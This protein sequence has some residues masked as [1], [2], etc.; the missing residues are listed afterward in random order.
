MSQPTRPSQSSSSGDLEGRTVLVF[1]A[2]GQ[3]AAGVVA[4][5]ADRGAHVQASA[6]DAARLD[7][8][9]ERIGASGGKM[10][11]EV[12][13]ATDDAAVGAYVDRVAASGRIDGVF[14]GIGATPAAL[15]YPARATELDLETFLRRPGSSPA[16]RS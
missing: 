14:N 11:T 4:E 10:T 8:L 1:A 13:D 16:R 12:V 9:A 3:I 7:R 6:R 2:T 5:L 15:G